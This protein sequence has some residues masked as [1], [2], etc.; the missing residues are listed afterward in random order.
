MDMHASRRSA[1]FTLIELMITVAIVAILAAI[2]LPAYDSYITK[3]RIKTAQ[4]DLVGLSLN[5]ENTY[6]RKLA[7]PTL[8]LANTAAVTG[9]FSAWHPAEANF[10]YS[11]SSSSTGYTLTA[12]G[13][14]GKV[15]GC[16][17][18][19]DNENARA[20]AQCGTYNGGWQ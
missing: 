19:L 9:E 6:Q 5:L 8:T 16:V 18:T 2:A 20:I 15:S 10:S 3:S 7:Y 1:G 12:T 4:A 13:S 14:A 11:A 17:I